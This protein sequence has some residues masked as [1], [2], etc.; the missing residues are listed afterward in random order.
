MNDH[1]LDALR[2]SF[3][4]DHYRT[5]KRPSWLH[6]FRRVRWVHVHG[7]HV[8]VVREKVNPRLSKLTGLK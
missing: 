3:F 8:P 7:P 2:Y 6:P 5:I 4:V 1:L